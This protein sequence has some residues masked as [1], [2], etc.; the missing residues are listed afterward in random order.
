MQA[1]ATTNEPVLAL[2]FSKAEDPSDSQVDDIVREWAPRIRYAEAI[3]HRKAVVSLLDNGSYYAEYGPIANPTEGDYSTGV[4]DREDWILPFYCEPEPTYARWRYWESEM[5]PG[6]KV[7]P[8]FRCLQLRGE[9]WIVDID[10]ERGMV[11]QVAALAVAEN[12][13]HLAR[14]ALSQ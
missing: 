2:Y 7:V 1:D 5:P 11:Q 6:Q 14:R 4:L 13:N 9:W 3:P 8:E 10:R 12:P